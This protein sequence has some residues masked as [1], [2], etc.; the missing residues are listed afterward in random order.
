VIRNLL[1]KF[2]WYLALALVLFVEYCD[3]HNIRIPYRQFFFDVMLGL[4]E[5]SIR[6]EP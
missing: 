5:T 2:L 3:R 4:N 6:L 1:S